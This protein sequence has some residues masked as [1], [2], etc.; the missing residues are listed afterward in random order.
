MLT[1]SCCDVGFSNG[2]CFA[3]P[4]MNRTR[5]FHEL[6]EEYPLE[7]R[8]GQHHDVARMVFHVE[9][10]LA[11]RE[12]GVS[13]ICDV[14]GGIGL[15]TPACAAAGFSRVVLV[16]DFQDE[17]N[18][19]T[20]GSVL[21]LHR[22]LGV[23]IVS[24]D[25]VAEGLEAAFAPAGFDVITC[26]DSME[27]WHH[28]PKVLLSEVVQLLKPGG[29]FILGVPNCVNLR[30]RLTM[31]LGRCKWS[32]MA[33]WYEKP[34]FRGHVREPDVD[35]L[36]YIARDMGLEQVAVYG[37]NWLGYYSNRAVVRGITR[38]SDRVLQ[39]FPSL[40]ANIYL[41]GHKRF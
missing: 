32:S 35:D 13:A 26:F 23:E 9:L 20:G 25:V 38:W 24:R 6:A 29:L 36:R 40:C 41:T 31:P 15:F 22:R 5:K 8:E 11:G 39:M 4:P 2:S 21:D 28:S 1:R 14:G 3:H 34:V 33:E 16:D 12:A 7:L 37:R 19:R 18:T 17:V 30:K 27:H 10:A